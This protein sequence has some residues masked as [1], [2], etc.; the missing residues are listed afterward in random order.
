MMKSMAMALLGMG[1]SATVAAGASAYPYTISEYVADH[2]GI[3]RVMYVSP[4]YGWAE[5]GQVWDMCRISGWGA[6]DSRG[7]YE[8][9]VY[10]TV[11]QFASYGFYGVNGI[12][13]YVQGSFETYGGNT[14]DVSFRLMGSDA[15]YEMANLIGNFDTCQLSYGGYEVI[16]R[17][18]EKSNWFVPVLGV[19]I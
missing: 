11:E 12:E 3:T 18:T 10:V 19:W 4:G 1:L 6:G 2:A 8:H 5:P 13:T 17:P 14:V 16:Y 7:T 9:V 15:S